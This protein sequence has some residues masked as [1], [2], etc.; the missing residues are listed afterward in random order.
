MAVIPISQPLAP[1]L[2]AA[3]YSPWS[4]ESQAR[5]GLHGKSG[6]FTYAD[7]TGL[8]GY[9]PDIPPV[10]STDFIST[11][12]PGG[13]DTI[14]SGL[15][16][17]DVEGYKYVYPRYTYSP[18]DGGWERSGYSEDRDTYDYYPYWPE[19]ISGGGT[20]LVGVELL[21]E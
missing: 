6:F 5:S 10:W 16:M 11:K 12:S 15:P 7:P 20:I 3:D 2:L 14:G 8:V 4:A 19:G 17:P 18:H 9:T 13:P 21:K 1:G